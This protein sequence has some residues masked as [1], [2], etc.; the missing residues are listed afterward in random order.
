M[1]A[2]LDLARRGAGRTSPNPLVGAVLSTAKGRILG[3]GHHARFGSAHAE[4]VLL[5]ALKGARVPAD[6]ILYVTLEPCAHQGKTP[7]CIE[8]LLASPIQRF[9]FATRDPDPRTSGRGIR[10]LRSAGRDVRVGL[11]AA[12]ARAM[13]QPFFLVNGR[14]RARVSV[15]IATTLDGKLADAWGRSKWITG[16]SSRD[17][18]QSLRAS[19]DAIVIGRGTL[20]ADDPRIRSRSVE[21]G[22]SRIVVSGSLDFDPECKLARIW[23]RETGWTIDRRDVVRETD[24]RRRTL[25]RVQERVGNWVRAGSPGSNLSLG[26]PKG[27]SRW[28]RRPRLIAAVAQAGPRKAAFFGRLGWEVWVLP[29]HAGTRVDLEALAR[30]ACAEGLSDL[31][32]EPGPRLSSALIDADLVDRLIL[33]V[34][35]VIVGGGAGWTADARPMHLEKA[36]RLVISDPTRRFGVDIGIEAQAPGD[37]MR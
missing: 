3:T 20:D 4:R 16:A 9:V 8:A 24:G 21:Q 6:A 13:N 34:A 32:F 26:K 10:A 12:E 36:R 7:P 14:G 18:V 17:D 2:A 31:L 35:P 22:Q 29:D 28:I 25:G 30:R 23:R 27:E 33:F 15:K 11:L 1:R 37:R 19:S 5:S